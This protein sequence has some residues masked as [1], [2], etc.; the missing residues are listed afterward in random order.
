MGHGPTCDGASRNNDL[1]RDGFTVSPETCKMGSL[2]TPL[3]GAGQGV[4]GVRVGQEG[5]GAGGVAECCE[6]VG[7][8]RAREYCTEY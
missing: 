8:G 6:N 2:G 7:S 5:R 3:R 4:E 1:H